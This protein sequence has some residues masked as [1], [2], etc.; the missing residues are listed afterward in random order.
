MH[1]QLKDKKE[2]QQL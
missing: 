1:T 2:T